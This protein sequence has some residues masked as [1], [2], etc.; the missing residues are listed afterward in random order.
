MMRSIIFVIILLAVSSSA[1]VGPTQAE[2]NLAFYLARSPGV[3]E[4]RSWTGSIARSFSWPTILVR[5]SY[6]SA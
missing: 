6:R 5:R 3:R 2:F 1:G 4:I